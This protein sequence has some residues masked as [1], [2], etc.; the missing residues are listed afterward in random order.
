MKYEYYRVKMSVIL[1]AKTDTT[2]IYSNNAYTPSIS[3]YL[4]PL[5]FKKLFD[6][7]FYSKNLSNY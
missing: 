2:E 3:K 5:T 7:L 6:C 4:T 1:R